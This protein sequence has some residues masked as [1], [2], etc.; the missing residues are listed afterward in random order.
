MYTIRH[1]LAILAIFHNF[2]GTLS[3]C[4]SRSFLSV[5]HYSHCM[6]SL[7]PV[8]PFSL[9]ACHSFLSA[10]D[11]PFSIQL[12]LF[13]HCICRSFPFSPFFLAVPALFVFLYLSSSFFTSSYIARH[14]GLRSIWFPGF[15]L[16]IFW[17][18][19]LSFSAGR[20]AIFAQTHKSCQT[21][22]Y[23]TLTAYMYTVSCTVRN[24]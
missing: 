24:N 6:P 13:S 7:V 2:L 3:L 16:D 18:T 8:A 12:Q 1:L 20:A 22:F 15:P 9:R 14:A 19:S 21:G 17:R 10:Y 23:L 11:T 4:V 5:F